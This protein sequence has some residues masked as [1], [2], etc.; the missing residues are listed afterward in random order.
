MRWICL[1][2]FCGRPNASEPRADVQTRTFPQRRGW[3]VGPGTR[4]GAAKWVCVKVGRPPQ[5]MAAV[6]LLSLST[7]PL[8]SKC[9]QTHRSLSCQGSNLSWVLR[10][11]PKGSLVAPFQSPLLQFDRRR[12][13]FPGAAAVHRGYCQRL[14]GRRLRGRGRRLS[15]FAAGKSY[16]GL[17]SFFWIVFLLA[18]KVRHWL[19]F[20]LTHLRDDFDSGKKRGLVGVSCFLGR[21]QSSS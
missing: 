6:L 12:Q 3:T 21:S 5:K 11:P 16:V 15:R 7:Q 1:A 20:P 4:D 13:Y 10:K 18:I 8:K 2:G 17:G 14:Q 19:L 9:T